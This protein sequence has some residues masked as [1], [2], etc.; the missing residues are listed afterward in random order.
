MKIDPK[1]V[2]EILVEI[3]EREESAPPKGP[4]CQFRWDGMDRRE[5]KHCEYVLEQGLVAP[6]GSAYDQGIG[7]EGITPAGYRWLRR[8][9]TKLHRW[10]FCAWSFAKPWILRIK[11]DF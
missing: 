4:A 1:R 2:S 6:W 11:P 8:N 3:Q 10:F 9:R 5:R 7:I